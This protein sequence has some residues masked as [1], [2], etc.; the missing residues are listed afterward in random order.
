VVERLDVHD[1]VQRKFAYSI[2]NEDCALPFSNY[3]AAVS[4]ADNGDGTSTVDWTGTFDARGVPEEDAIKVAT[5]IYP[6]AIKGAQVA[7]EK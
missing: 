5:G 7:L 4:I 6:G 1:A 3:S 2:I